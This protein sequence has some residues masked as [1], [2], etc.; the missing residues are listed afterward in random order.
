LDPSAVDIPSFPGM[1]IIFGVLSVVGPTAGAD[2]P[3]VL[4]IHADVGVSVVAG[5]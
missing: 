2:I 5:V 3:A 4:C 1:S